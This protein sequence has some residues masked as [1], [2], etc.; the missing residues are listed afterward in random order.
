MPVLSPAATAFSGEALRYSAASRRPKRGF[1]KSIDSNEEVAPAPSS[2]AAASELCHLL[3]EAVTGR[4]LKLPH[5]EKSQIR[6]KKLEAKSR[7]NYV[8]VSEIK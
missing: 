1:S 7:K 6:A 2:A 5:G 3:L 4:R 8:A